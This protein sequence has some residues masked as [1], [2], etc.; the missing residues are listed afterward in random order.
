MY[1]RGK[2]KCTDE[3]V[4]VSYQRCWVSHE[5]ADVACCL[6]RLARVKSFRT[7]AHS[8]L[9]ILPRARRDILYHWVFQFREV[10]VKQKGAPRISISLGQEKIKI[11]ENTNLQIVDHM[12]LKNHL[13]EFSRVVKVGC[14][15]FWE[16]EIP[17]D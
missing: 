13:I 6:N 17:I 7:R 8:H 10:P 16:R 1:N 9:H 5:F 12:G 14:L 11:R 4:R 3:E 15:R 2:S